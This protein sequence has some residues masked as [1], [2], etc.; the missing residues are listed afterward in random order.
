MA[1][2]AIC[3]GERHFGGREFECRGIITRKPD[4]G[5]HEFECY[6]IIICGIV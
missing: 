5:S 2:D 6:V 1:P 3:A 4:L